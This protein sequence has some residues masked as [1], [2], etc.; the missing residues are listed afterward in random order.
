MHRHSRTVLRVLLVYLLVLATVPGLT[1]LAASA[2]TPQP[3]SV[4]TKSSRVTLPLFV[5]VSGVVWQDLDCDGVRE[6]GEPPFPSVTVELYKEIRPGVWSPAPTATTDLAGAFLLQNV[7]TG[8]TYKLRFRPQA[9]YHFAPVDAGDDSVDSDAHANGW[10]DPRVI[11]GATSGWDAGLCGN[12]SISGIKWHDLDGKGDPD[13]GE[14]GLPGW[15][16]EL[17]NAQGNV[18][19]TTTG[20]NGAYTFDNLVAGT[21][22][23]TEELQDGWRQTYPGRDGSHSVTL[24]DEDAS[25]IGFGNRGALSISGAKWHDLNGD[26]VWDG[27][28]LGLSG[29]TIELRNPQGALVA[30]TTTNAN[31]AYSFDNL[32]PGDYTVSEVQQTGW[33]QTAPA[34]GEYLITLPDPQGGDG[35]ATHKDFG[36]QQLGDLDVTK[37]V[38]WNGVTEV[39]TQTFTICIAPAGTVGAAVATAGDPY[40]HTY[41][42][43]GGS[44]TWSDLIP[45]DYG[46]VETP[47]GSGWTV[48]GS[49][50]TVTVPANGGSV[51]TT[52][53]NTRKLGGLDVVKMVDWNGVTP[54]AGQ[55]FTFTITG[56]SFPSGDSKS[57]NYD[58]GTASWSGLVPGVYTVT[59]TSPG[60]QWVT[61]PGLSQQVTVPADGGTATT[62]FTNTRLLGGLT[63]VKVVDWNGVPANANQTFKV[64]VSP[65]VL[66]ASALQQADGLCHTFGWEGGFHTFQGLVPGDYVV[67][68][69]DPGSAWT[70]VGSGVTVTVPEDGSAVSTTITN[71]RKLGGLDVVKVVNWNGVPVDASQTLIFTI[72]GPSYPSGN[73][74]SVD[75]DGGTVSWDN[76]VPGTYTVTETSPGSAWTVAPGLSQDVTVP[77]DGGTATATFTNTRLLAGLQIVKSVTPASAD[78]GDVVAY[79]IA[80]TNIGTMD[81]TGVTITD[82]PDWTYVASALANGTT[83]TSGD[84]VWNIGALATGA[85]GTVTYQAT[86]EGEDAFDLGQTPVD[87]LAVIT[88]DQA[89]PAQDTATVIVTRLLDPVPALRIEKVG[90]AGTA[91][92]GDTVAYTI[93]VQNTGNITLTNV[94]VVD[95]KLGSDEDLGDLAPGASKQVTGS[96]LVTEDDM[97]GIIN[98]AVADSDQTDPVDDT[99]TVEVISGPALRIEKV[100]STATAHIGDSVAY[101]ITVRN[102]GDITLTHVTMAD[103]M[104][105]IVRAWE[106]LAPGASAVVTAPYTIASSD[107][108]AIVNTAV[109]DSDQTGPVE[110]TW[111]VTVA[112]QPGLIIVKTV[113][114]PHAMVGDLITF[115]LTVSNTGD[116][117]LTDV[118]I[119]DEL[120]GVSQNV[121]NLAVGQ[122]DGAC[123]ASVQVPYT[124][125]AEDLP[126]IHNVATATGKDPEGKTVSDQDDATVVIDRKYEQ[127]PTP[128][129]CIRSDVAVVIYGGW[130]GIPVKAWVGGTEQQ[131]LY[132]AVDSFG[133]QQVMWTFYPPENTSWSVS[134]QPQT[135]EGKDPARWQYKLLRIESPSQGTVNNNPSSASVSI[136]RCNQYVIY[137]QLVDLGAA[138]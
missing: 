46:V 116:V 34:G 37:V 21:Y 22:T 25:E 31:G 27:D 19:T 76:L 68:E 42:S 93:T 79:T 84:I 126:A 53:T 104:L 9:G 59:E 32:V 49:G 70:V 66:E 123:T 118:T 50:V 13:D 24:D 35:C 28:E 109:A 134:V 45:G 47:P 58:G 77:A 67:T 1:A 29:W 127:P 60:S 36:N 95:G 41:D 55:T 99:W 51:S 101:T 131:T 122:S 108:G 73:S 69:T 48:A 90:S 78:P 72:T 10:T 16:I 133:E 17:E 64:C 5:P 114:T 75:H 8:R 88:S 18:I 97:E 83:Y 92:I 94:T 98:T 117:D 86:L 103:A 130:N 81:L 106:A 128:A 30:S 125:T 96:Y 119:V 129:P 120:L 100:G 132:T 121:G 15:T 40:C 14:P 56:A 138:P 89:G 82:T 6:G 135:P 57:V 39:P 20:A 137:F 38:E 33:Q 62:T 124:V 43:D 71:T 11:M 115:T 54:D 112:I 7:Q 91:H 85:S 136:T 44:Y 107:I 105:G 111:A 26:R 52:I 113:S 4:A 2:E 110:R 74:K 80:Y 65:A 102:T 12:G 23:V 61:L 3:G 63:V 87:N